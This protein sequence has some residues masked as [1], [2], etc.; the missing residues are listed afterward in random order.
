MWTDDTDKLLPPLEAGVLGEGFE[1]M[2]WGKRGGPWKLTVPHFFLTCIR[3][4]FFQVGSPKLPFLLGHYH[5][6]PAV[7]NETMILVLIDRTE[8]GMEEAKV[9]VNL[10]EIIKKEDKKN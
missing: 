7:A 4:F 10:S 6:G 1:E 9:L 8:M 3:L 5:G 2:K